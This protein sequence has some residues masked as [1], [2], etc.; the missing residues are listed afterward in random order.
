LI[1]AIPNADTV[2]AVKHVT[3]TAPHAYEVHIAGTDHQSLTDLALTSPFL[4]SL[5]TN[6][7]P[8]AGGGEA[9]DKLYVVEKMNEIVLAFFN[10][11]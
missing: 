6:A 9:A 11:I 5:I 10:V 2:V 4:V 8:K 3:A 1:A 7:V